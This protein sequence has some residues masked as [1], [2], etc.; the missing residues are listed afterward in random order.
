MNSQWRMGKVIPM[1]ILVV[2]ALGVGYCL[3]RRSAPT[4]S[5]PPIV[6][7]LIDE[8]LSLVK[9]E[10]GVR[11][12][13]V[14]RLISVPVDEVVDG[15]TL[16]VLWQGEKTPLRYYGVN[17]P[18]REKA[19]YGEA[20]ERNRVL[21]GASVRLAFDGRSRDKY[22]RLLAY[23]LT[24]DGRAIEAALVA[25]RFGRA[26]TRDGRFRNQMVDLEREARSARRG[27]LWKDGG[28]RERSLGRNRR[29]KKSS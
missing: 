1:T 29:K 22:G 20:T 19:C 26:W 13:D 6:P 21:A 10:G 27:C 23:V 8:D 18:E 15:D 28:K 9:G 24:E 3:G 7:T 11:V 17:T 14:S 16:W 4:S 5:V 2:V 25:E 12:S